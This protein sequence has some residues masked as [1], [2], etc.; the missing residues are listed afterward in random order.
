MKKT[1]LKVLEQLIRE[2]WSRHAQ[3]AHLQW[4]AGL[5]G[6]I[7]IKSPEKVMSAAGF[8]KAVKELIHVFSQEAA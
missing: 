3:H 5:G 6:H 8:K 7:A 4:P 1:Q 2:Y